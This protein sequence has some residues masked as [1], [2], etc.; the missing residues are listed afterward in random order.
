[1]GKKVAT[2]ESKKTI[3]SSIKKIKLLVTVVNR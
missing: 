2:V 3:S 1:M